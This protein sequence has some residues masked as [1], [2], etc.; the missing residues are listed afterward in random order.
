MEPEAREKVALTIKN[1]P[2]HLR[3]QLARRAAESHRSLNGEILHILEAAIRGE[4]P[5]A[6][7]AD[8]AL[9]RVRKLRARIGGPGLTI[10]EVDAAVA[11]G[12]P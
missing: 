8:D 3:S 12:R 2:A 4:N 5:G 1:V 11:E 9:S 6:S 7:L 10:D